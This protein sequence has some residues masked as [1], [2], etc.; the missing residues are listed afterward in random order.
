M[1][2]AF[3]R[4]AAHHAIKSLA[5]RTSGSIGHESTATR[6]GLHQALFAQ[7][8]HRFTNRRAAY[9]KLLREIPFGGQLFAPLQ[10]ALEYGIFYLLNDLFVQPQSLDNFIHE[11]SWASP[12]RGCLPDTNWSFGRTTIQQAVVPPQGLAVSRFEALTIHNT[13]AKELTDIC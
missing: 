3:G 1:H 8:L 9:A 6:I 12:L 11:S 5:H 2:G 10:V 13:T 4:A 7:G